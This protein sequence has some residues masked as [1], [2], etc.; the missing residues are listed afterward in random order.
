MTNTMNPETTKTVAA[1]MAKEE[2]SARRRINE[3]LADFTRNRY[4]DGLPISALCA[5]L[6]AEGF[7]A[8]NLMGIY[9]GA[10]GKVHEQVGP[11]T[12]FRMD[13]YRMESGR[14]EVT[15]YLS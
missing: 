3:K 4:F 12:W 13:W 8:E 14:Y 6:E 11:R 10:T 5:M 15:A 7:D 1:R 2:V 9:C